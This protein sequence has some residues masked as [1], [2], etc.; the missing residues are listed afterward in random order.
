MPAFRQK[1]SDSSCDTGCLIHQLFIGNPLPPADQRDLPF[2]LSC[3]LQKAC[4]NPGV[5]VIPGIRFIKVKDYTF[6]LFFFQDGKFAH[7]QVR[8][9]QRLFQDLYQA[10]MQRVNLRRREY[11]GQVIVIHYELI[12]GI[13]AA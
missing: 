2:I 8:I 4:S 1:L 6:F 13:P 11:L 10:A 7:R 12:A 3:C 5:P 9:L